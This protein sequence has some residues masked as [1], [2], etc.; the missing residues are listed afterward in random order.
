[1]T[2]E[3]RE[4]GWQ[5]WEARGIESS[6]ISFDQQTYQS[7][8]WKRPHLGVTSIVGSRGPERESSW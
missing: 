3:C 4:R 6:L 8:S 7:W 1:M 5:F 2:R